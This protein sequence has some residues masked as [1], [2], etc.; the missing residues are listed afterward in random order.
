MWGFIFVMYSLKKTENFYLKNG[1]KQSG[2]LDPYLF[3]TYIDPLIKNIQSSKI[4]CFVGDIAS[5]VIS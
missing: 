1:A 3:A 4:G 2:V 5:N